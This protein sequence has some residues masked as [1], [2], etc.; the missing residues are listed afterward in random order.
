LRRISL[1]TRFDRHQAPALFDRV[2]FFA[3]RRNRSRRAV[4]MTRPALAPRLAIGASANVTAP[5]RREAAA[6]GVE[7][8]RGDAYGEIRPARLP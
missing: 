2:A 3:G 4:R 6:A 7:M 8:A 5:N 1:V